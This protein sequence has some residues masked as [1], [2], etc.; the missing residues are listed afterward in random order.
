MKKE[1]AQG[2]N[3]Y[4][5]DVSVLYIKWHN[6]HWNVVGPQFKAVHEYLEGLY[7]GLADVLDEAAEMLKINEE[8]PLASMKEFL[9]VSTVEE[10]PSVEISVAEAIKIVTADMEALKKVAEEVRVAADEEDAYDVVGMLEGHLTDYNKN[11]WF[12]KAMVK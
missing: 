12:V 6:L 1:I 8:T 7:D 11:I 5:A 4:L 9:A 3:K 2:L 10:L